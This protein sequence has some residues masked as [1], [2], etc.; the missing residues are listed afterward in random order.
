MST[1]HKIWGDCV[2]LNTNEQGVVWG[3]SFTLG[4]LLYIPA[5]PMVM[6]GRSTHLTTLFPGQA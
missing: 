4:L 2:L 3:L 6:S 5:T 1:L